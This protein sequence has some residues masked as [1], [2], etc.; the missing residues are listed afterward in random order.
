MAINSGA[1]PI[2]GRVVAT[3]GNGLLLVQQRRRKPAAATPRASRAD[4]LLRAAGRALSHPGLPRSSVFTAPGI[5]AYYVD[6]ND[7][8]L[9]IRE[10][11]DGTRT[12]V[13]LVDGEVVPLNAS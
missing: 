9:L 1:P 5:F 11:Q 13:H 12:P 4:T 8:T 2:R 10:S 6:G 3:L 7:P